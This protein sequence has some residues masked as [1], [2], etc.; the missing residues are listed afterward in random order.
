MM[1]N[2]L[3]NTGFLL[4]HLMT[5]DSKAVT[6]AAFHSFYELDDEVDIDEKKKHLKKHTKD[7]WN[8]VKDLSDRN[9]PLGLHKH[10]GKEG[11]DFTIMFIPNDEFL[12][13]A[14]R[15]LQIITK[16]LRKQTK[17]AQARTQTM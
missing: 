17:Q 10:L 3:E 7:V 5:I 4:V 11:P 1:K 9:Y 2:S 8:Q 16:A 14:E 12:V 13:R 6:K 15:G